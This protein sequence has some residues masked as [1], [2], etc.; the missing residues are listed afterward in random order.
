MCSD[1]RLL[2]LAVLIVAVSCVPYK[3]INKIR[4]GEVEVNLSVSDEKDRDETV[5]DDDGINLIKGDLADGPVI[6]NAIRDAETGEMVATDIIKASKVTARFRN[7]AERAGLVTIFFD[8]TVPAGMADS[9]WQL[10]ILPYL[11][12]QKD[13]AALEPIYITGSNYR[14]AQL[15]GYQRY[16]EFMA[17]IISDT[18][19]FIRVG[20]LEIFL[21]R[22]FPDTYRMKNDST[23]IPE[24]LA[25][26]LFG[27]TQ[28]EALLHYKRQLKWKHNERRK[29]MAGKM[30]GKYVKDPIVT[31]GIRLDTV[32]AGMEGDF[33]YRYSQTFRSRPGLK[34]VTVS[35]EGSLYEMGERILTLPFPKDLTFYISSLSSLA[36]MTPMYRMIVKERVVHD[37]TKALIDFGQGSAVVDTCLSDNA[38]EL[39]RVRRC[40]SDVASVDGLVADSI[41]IVASCSPEGL[42]ASNRKLSE[43]RADAVLKYVSAFVPHEWNGIL[44][45]SGLPENWEQFMKLVKSDTVITRKAKERILEL[46]VDMGNPDEVEAK[47]SAMPEYR[48]LREKVYPKLRSVRFDFYL[49]RTGMAKDTVH[50][51]ELDTLYMRGMQA[52]RDLDYKAA[53]RILRPYDDYNAALAFVSAGYDHS[54]LDVLGRLGN[55]DPKVCYLMALVLSRLGQRDEAMKYLELSI[56]YDYAM[57]HRA[58]LDPEMYMLIKHRKTN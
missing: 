32:I 46:C 24:P 20:Q 37:N 6:M 57:E 38:S 54:A 40:F 9:R 56:A 15:R 7:V 14:A 26:N 10:K 48:Y 50:T 11:A 36:D 58:N 18:V 55:S 22:Y 51:T 23:L 49:H 34:K 2:A 5:P 12:I 13:T 45:A 4:S 25:G 42:Y 29:G 41:L 47:I 53:V 28:K 3:K 44:R 1:V 39:R 21:S 30:Y 17:S 52:L 35:L 43:A 27:V 19:D 31:D 8:I 16:R 33:T